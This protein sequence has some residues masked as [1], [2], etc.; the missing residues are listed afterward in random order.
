MVATHQGEA[1]A[2]LK[3]KRTIS[4]YAEPEQRAFATIEEGQRAGGD[5]LAVAETVL[6]IIRSKAPARYYLV[7][8]EKWYVRLSRFLPPS[9]TE[10]LVT[11]HFRLTR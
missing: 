1:F 6:R 8:T 9:A 2:Q 10:S 5:P 3:V 11:R 4:D 7:G